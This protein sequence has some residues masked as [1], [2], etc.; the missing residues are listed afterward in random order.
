MVVGM[1]GKSGEPRR[2]QA[3]RSKAPV[4][5]N[6]LQPSME[7]LQMAKI[8]GDQYPSDL[9]DKVQQVRGDTP[10]CLPLRFWYLVTV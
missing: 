8:L 5:S 6:K 7:A 2:G 1:S 9:T 4:S 3:A 10:S